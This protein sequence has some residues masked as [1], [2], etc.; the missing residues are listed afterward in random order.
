MRRTC[1]RIMIDCFNPVIEF[2][3][4]DNSVP[5]CNETEIFRKAFT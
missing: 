4:Q 1:F 3:L 2:G 5:D